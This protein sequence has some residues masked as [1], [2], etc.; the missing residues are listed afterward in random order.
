MDYSTA[1]FLQSA[2]DI[3]LF[4]SFALTSAALLSI[5]S[6]K[7]IPLLAA[8]SFL[9]VAVGGGTLLL[10]DVI[11]D[12]KQQQALKALQGPELKQK[13]INPVHYN[14]IATQASEIFSKS[15][16]LT[17][18]QYESLD[19][20]HLTT[21]N[22][23]QPQFSNLA[24]KPAVCLVVQEGQGGMTITV[25]A[26]KSDAQISDGIA[27]TL[28]SAAED[29]FKPGSYNKDTCDGFAEEQNQTLKLKP[30]A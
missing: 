22:S 26:Q 17:Q 15:I 18:E 11:N 28:K 23:I 10:P 21:I 9:A 2:K 16:D 29:G 1:L 12:L 8:S 14:L 20:V 4:G 5:N 6:K 24:Q 25:N 27:Q 30:T 3:S 7:C 19:K 13:V